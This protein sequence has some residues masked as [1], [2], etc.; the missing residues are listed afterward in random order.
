MVTPPPISAAKGT[1]QYVSVPTGATHYYSNCR[2]V[3]YVPIMESEWRKSGYLPRL[4]APSYGD[5]SGYAASQSFQGSQK[6]SQWYYY[7]SA[8]NDRSLALLKSIGINAIRV[9]TNIFVWEKNPEKHW[10]DV[11]DFMS[12][13]N[14]HKMRVQFVL[15]DS[16]RI[17][18]AGTNPETGESWTEPLNTAQSASSL[19]YC[20]MTSWH[21]VPHTYQSLINTADGLSFINTS[22]TPFIHQLV[23]SVSSYQSFWSIDC[24]NEVGGLAVLNEFVSATCII[25]SSVVSS[26]GT[27]ITVGWAGGT[28]PYSGIAGYEINIFNMLSGIL[29]FN[30]IHPYN[31]NGVSRALYVSN[32]AST[33]LQ[34]GNPSMANEVTFPAQGA[35]YEN[36]VSGF[37]TLNYGHMCW[38]GL[39]ERPQSSEP[40]NTTNGI[41]FWDGQTR[42]AA[43]ADTYSHFAVE[44]GWI[45]S[46]QVTRNNVEKAIS[47][48][49]GVDGGYF[50][51]VVAEH[52]EYIPATYIS[53]VE[54]KW[55][56]AKFKEYQYSDLEASDPELAYPQGFRSHN[57]A[58]YEGHPMDRSRPNYAF[59]EDRL[60]FSG[61]LNILQNWD[62]YW[63]PL[64]EQPGAGSG[65]AFRDKDV[66]IFKRDEIFTY[67]TTYLG[68]QLNYNN[69]LSGTVHDF[70]VIPTAN[71]INFSSAYYPFSRSDGSSVKCAVGP[72]QV[73][74]S[75]WIPCNLK[76]VGGT[77][78]Y[79]DG[80]TS[81]FP[82]SWG[83]YDNLYSQCASA[84]S[85]CIDF[86]L[87]SGAIDSRYSLYP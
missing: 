26:V 75:A 46:K 52:L 37:N 44:A 36:D 87:A 48:N 51:G 19:D 24:A 80:T 47:V 41:M 34:N 25:V 18:S 50:S 39:I 58:P 3:N 67:A 70:S 10:N 57:Y 28:Y 64:A 30:S 49:N 13:C 55:D 4:P 32:A 35:R 62:T 38:D 56:Y 65:Q 11:K 74:T 27:P 85:E 1:S 54:A 21:R 59:S 76:G 42:D 72:Y 69:T 84:L 16:I 31:N 77:C 63:T 7:D 8:D 53:A 83:A 40:F 73:G 14:K 60:D 78:L 5:G 43:A 61:M 82:I 2:G 29:N 6:A 86:I 79:S 9:F 81:A 68:S 71:Q 33:T 22:A 17:G 20:L 15:W 66:D 23:S 45:T 12:L